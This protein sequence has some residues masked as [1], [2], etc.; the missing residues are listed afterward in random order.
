MGEDH[1]MKKIALILSLMLSLCLPAT[2]NPQ[3][4]PQWRAW[5]QPV[6]PYHIIGNVWYVGAS[7]VT[8]F[9]ITTSKG[10]ILLDSGF[11]ETVPQIK[12]NMAQ[13][14]FKLTDIKIL[15]NSHAHSD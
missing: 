14:G 6:K 11:S 13:L 15:I 5:N 8:S 1:D 4:D 9:L 7:G 12:Q 2:A 10:H 3:D